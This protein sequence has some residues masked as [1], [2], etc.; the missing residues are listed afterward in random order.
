MVSGSGSKGA[1]ILNRLRFYGRN[2]TSS[3][4]I[5]TLSR[6]QFPNGG[7][8]FTQPQTGWSNPMPKVFSFDRTVQ[9]IIRHRMANPAITAKHGLSLDTKAVETELE[10]FTRARLGMSQIGA[11]APKMNPQQPLPQ[12]VVGAVEGLKRTAAGAGAVI[13][14]L[15]SGGQAVPNELSAKRAARCVARADGSKCPKMGSA[16]LAAWYVKKA[17]ELIEKEIQKRNDLQLSTPHDAALGVCSACL[18]PMKLK[19][20]TPLEIIE[21]HTLPAVRADLDP[22]CWILAQDKI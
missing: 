16:D 3:V 13:E 11:A 8:Q 1:T 22:Q 6:S 9:E 17:A 12:A 14:W 19:V 4:M 21:K 10:N 5:E 20:H 7:W 2:A 15:G 18:C